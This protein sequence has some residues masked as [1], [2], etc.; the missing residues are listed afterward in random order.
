MRKLLLSIFV[1]LYSF[2]INAQVAYVCSRST[3]SKFH[4]NPECRGLKNCGSPVK[5]TTVAYMQSKGRLACKI[6]SS[7]LLSSSNTDGGNNIIS[8]FASITPIKTIGL[9]IP[10]TSKGIT[11]QVIKHVGYTT[12]YNTNWL[13]PN[14][15]AYELTN[16]E[17]KG[18][19]PRPQIEFEPDPKVKGKVATHYDYSNSGYSRSHMAPAADMKWSQQA[20]L[21]SFYTSNICPQISGLN[22][23][24]WQRLEDRCRALTTDGSIFIC[25]GPIVSTNPKRIGDN[26]VAVPTNF[27]KVL[28]M[29]RKGKWQAI[30]F[31]FP[32]ENCKGS[33][34]D[35]ALT[36]DEV[37]K[38]T[39]HDFFNGLPDEIENAIESSWKMKDWQ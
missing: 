30:G 12:S 38:L 21:Q 7:D 34:F 31:V 39:G 36:V 32:N 2:C 6:C 26:R 15:V 11:Q 9:E 27:F 20:M 4:L 33:M 16:E 5:K 1:S 25:C 3:K 19:I 23:G 29:L 8:K 13:I 35:Y 24:V 28:C 22:G 10:K 37:E 18:A 17:V 14:W